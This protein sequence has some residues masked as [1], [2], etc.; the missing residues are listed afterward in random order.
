MPS[1][2]AQPETTGRA[3]DGARTRAREVELAVQSPLPA[4]LGELG[5]HN[6]EYVPGGTVSLCSG[7]CASRG[8]ASE[9]AWEVI[10]AAFPP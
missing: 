6:Q 4:A 2:L 7:C 1:I 3:C 8:F 10:A 9:Q 5:V